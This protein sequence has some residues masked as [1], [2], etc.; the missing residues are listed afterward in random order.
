MDMIFLCHSFRLV[1]AHIHPL[2]AISLYA[3]FYTQ[4]KI[5]LTL[6]GRNYLQLKQTLLFTC[7]LNLCSYLL[8]VIQNHSSPHPSQNIYNHPII[9]RLHQLHRLLHKIKT[10]LEKPANL[11]PQIHKLSQAVHLLNQGHIDDDYSTSSHSHHGKPSSPSHSYTST[12]SSSSVHS[13]QTE[14]LQSNQFALRSSDLLP[15]PPSITNSHILHYG[16]H[17]TQPS[18]ANQHLSKT[19]N[20]ITQ[21]QSNKSK[22]PREKVSGDYIDDDDANLQKGLAMMDAMLPPESDDED[23]PNVHHS[24]NEHSDDPDDFYT[25]IQNHSKHRKKSKKQKYAVQ[26]KLPRLDKEVEGERPISKTILK[27]RGLVPHKHKRNRNPRVKKREQYR[28][29]LIKRRGTVRELRTGTGEAEAY[30]GEYTGINARVSRSR[31]LR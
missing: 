9:A 12:S 16:D 17:T 6:N 24:D 1:H 30:G 26:P 7:A 15:L 11:L 8:L 25:Q 3:H 2:P 20:T 23:A 31:K 21:K 19:L 14:P 22:H 29:A 5:G 13:S 4:Q 18:H 28:K 10:D 27:N